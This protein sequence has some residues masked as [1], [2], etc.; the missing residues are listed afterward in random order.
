MLDLIL[1]VFITLMTALYA[2]FGNNI[3]IAIVVLTVIIRMLTYPLFARQQQTSKKMQQLQPRLKKLQE[4]YKDDREKLAQAQMELYRE[5][6]VNPLGGCL[7]LLLQFPILI[8]LY[9]GIFFALASTPF[10]LVD[11]PERLLVTGL[12]GLIPLENIW[13]GMDLRQPP[14]PPLNP[15]YALALPA[16][17]L[18]TTWLQTRFTM[19]QS[20]PSEDGKPDQAAA[21]T[22][23]MTTIMPI[24][25]GFIS[26]TLS[27]GLSIYFLTSN[28]MSI[29]QYSPI[30]KKY[31]DPIFGIKPIPEVDDEPPERKKKEKKSAP[32]DSA[33]EPAD[34]PAKSAQSAATRNTPNRE[35]G[36]Q[37][38]KTATNIKVK[39]GTGSKSKKRKQ[40]RR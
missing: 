10:Q 6:G 1:N 18:V 33:D 37:A 3:V 32:P 20:K 11:L 34:E 30:G 22:R 17:V 40:S 24:M 35:K 29:I 38:S 26:L 8:G 4:K 9:Q 13:L 12:D 14:T 2:L 7:P 19:P 36:A 5:A 21:M 27:V 23:S 39:S 25:F 31:I 28:L 16:L 15:I